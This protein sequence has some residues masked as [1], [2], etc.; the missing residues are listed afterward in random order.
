MP[1]THEYLVLVKVR[2]GD[3]F[4]PEDIR[5]AV[6]GELEI[7]VA[8]QETALLAQVK[9]AK[10]LGAFDLAFPVLPPSPLG[11]EREVHE[12]W[13]REYLAVE[14]VTNTQVGLVLLAV[15]TAMGFDIP[16]DSVL[17]AQGPGEASSATYL[18]GGVAPNGVPISA[19]VNV[20]P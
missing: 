19:Q 4:S 20:T 7:A 10:A 9:E 8:N 18:F 13:M 1:D 17:G 15:L 2:T 12:D 6:H 3:K 11:A 5:E 14:G 16:Q